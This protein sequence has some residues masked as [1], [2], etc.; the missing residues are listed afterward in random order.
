[1]SGGCAEIIAPTVFPDRSRVWK[2]L[3]AKGKIP[4]RRSGAASV[5]VGTKLYIFGGYGGNGRLAD[6]FCYNLEQK[7]WTEIECK[8]SAPGVR[9]N[10]GLVEWNG[11][12]YLFGGYNGTTWLGMWPTALHRERPWVY[13]RE[14]PGW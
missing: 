5:M 9:E 3:S 10:N 7:T 6:F 4:G 12:L 11:C 8:G 14:V 2:Q 1:M 13:S